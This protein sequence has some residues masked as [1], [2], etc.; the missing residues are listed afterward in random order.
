[1][2]LAGDGHIG[3]CENLNFS[4]EGENNGSPTG[5]DADG[6]KGRVQNE[7]ALVANPPVALL[8]GV[9]VRLTR[10]GHGDQP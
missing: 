10:L 9:L 6:L 3:L 2:V 8:L 7:G 1:M 4:V 5:D